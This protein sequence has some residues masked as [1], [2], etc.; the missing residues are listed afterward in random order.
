MA[1]FTTFLLLLVGLSVTNL[2]LAHESTNSSTIIIHIDESGYRQSEITVPPGTTVQFENVGK[3]EFWPAT[4][5]HPSHTLYD[6][7]GLEEHCDSDHA[8]TFDACDGIT[9][10]STWSFTFTK[11]GVFPFHDHF[12]PQFVGTV[13]VS[14]EEK[15]SAN[16]FHSLQSWW[17]K[18]VDTLS[19]WFAKNEESGNDLLT[20]SVATDAY[21]KLRDK[22]VSLVQE[23]NPR[24]AIE[25]LRA[26]SDTA[27]QVAALCHDILHDIGKAAYAK[28]GS[29]G[30]A[31]AF[32]SDFC[33]SGYIHGLFES[34]FA[35]GDE[36]LKDLAAE[37][38]AYASL[39]SRLFDLWQC[40]HGVGH[41]FMYFTGGNL[42]ASLALCA[43]GFVGSG[44]E[45]CQNGAYMEVFNQEILANEKGAV[46]PDNPFSVC[47]SRSIA[48]GECY[49]YV[50]TYLSQTAKVS[51]GDM[52]SLCSQA[53]KFKS[54]CL[55]GIGSET[56]KRNM[57]TPALVFALC[58]SQNLRQDSVSCQNGAVGMYLNQIGSYT[59]TVAMCETLAQD[60]KTTCLETAA[61]AEPLFI[62]RTD[63]Y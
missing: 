50:P 39:G 47:N 42:D 4:D 30:D 6:G 59:D 38:R 5:H 61:R 21:E 3:S 17:R 43:E 51:F 58:S 60:F 44:A 40:H 62:T 53:G 33:N 36:P 12:W 41:G 18:A 31:I 56:M 48:Q 23:S 52:F 46:D 28:Y 8:P 24:V 10:G 14:G 20:G 35:S 57:H 37:C 22:Y 15:S 63:L 45:S 25:T 29:F 32:Q 2:A 54:S 7:T 55:S 27:D 13:T 9:P 16:I 26:E 34:H 19:D 49:T 11:N 1:N